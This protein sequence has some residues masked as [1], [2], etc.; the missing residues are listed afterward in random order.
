MP[1]NSLDSLDLLRHI[2]KLAE[3]TNLLMEKKGKSAF[4]RY[5]IT[6]TIF[7]LFGVAAFSEG[8]KG[9]LADLGLIDHSIALLVVGFAILI[10]TGTVFKKLDK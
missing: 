2:E 1:N 3:N 10:V 4:S 9:V 8:L 6:F 7:V 5:P